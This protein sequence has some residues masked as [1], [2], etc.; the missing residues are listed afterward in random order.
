MGDWFGGGRSQRIDHP[1]HDPCVLANLPAAGESELLEELDGRA[2][3][4]APG[5]SRPVYVRDGLD[6][7]AASVSDLVESTYQR[8]PRDALAAMLFIPWLITRRPVDRGRSGQCLTDDEADDGC[9]SDSGEVAI[10]GP[11]SGAQRER[12]HHASE[13][14]QPGEGD[15]GLHAKVVG[16]VLVGGAQLVDVRRLRSPDR[17]RCRWWRPARP[18]GTRPVCGTP[19]GNPSRRTAGQAAVRQGRGAGRRCA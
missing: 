2:Q 11:P 19:S 3:Q 10:T 18:D 15:Q 9:R 4:E 13:Q 7:A 12:S 8:G 17:R 6:E 14:Q 16:L 5:A 1:A